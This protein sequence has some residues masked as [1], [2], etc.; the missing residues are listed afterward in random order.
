[1]RP[2]RKTK[3]NSS[4]RGTDLIAVSNTH[5]ESVEL[6]SP[7]LLHMSSSFGFRLEQISALC[8]VLQKA[9]Q[10][11]KLARFI[12]SLP[13]CEQLQQQEAIMKARAVV[14]FHK[15]NFRD[16]YKILETHNYQPENHLKLQQLWLKEKRIALLMRKTLSKVSLNFFFTSVAKL[17]ST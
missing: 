12:A 17:N 8:E 13:K 9:G 2:G 11:D 16:L 1:M 14:Y 10:I 5:G 7:V 15:G 6:D 4:Y 3:R